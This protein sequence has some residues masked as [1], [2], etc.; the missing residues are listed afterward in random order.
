MKYLERIQIS[1]AA[2]R[3]NARM[4]QEE[5]AK[6]LGISK[7]TI[8]NWENGRAEPKTSQARELSKIYNMP[9]EYIFFEEKS[10]LI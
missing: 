9:L 6:K 2:A 3:V 1:L 7:Q 4:T 10:N 5:A 8:V